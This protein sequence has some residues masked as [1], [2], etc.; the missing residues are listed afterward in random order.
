MNVQS[1]HIFIIALLLGFSQLAWAESLI[2]PVHGLG[3][4]PYMKGQDP[5]HGS[6]I[7]EEQIRDR[8]TVIAPYTKWI[9]SYG[10]THGLEKIGA[11]AHE[12]GLKAAV[13]IWL[14]RDYTE[15]EAQI[16]NAITAAQ[17]GEVDMLIVGNEV[18]LRGDLSEA[19]LIGYINRVKQE[20][21]GI[22]VGYADVYGKFLEY[23]AVVEASD[24]ILA[25]Y[26]PYWEGISINHAME[27]VDFRHQQIIALANGKP[28]I[29]GE[30]G[31]PSDGNTL[32]DAVPSPENAAFYFLS[33]TSW[34]LAN[35]ADYFYFEAFD[36]AWK[37][38]YEGPQG[39]HW[40]VWDEDGILK[41]GMQ[42]VFDGSLRNDVII[43][44]GASYGI[45]RWMNN[46]KWLQLH[47]LSPE[48]MVT[49]DIDGNAQDDVIIDFGTQYGIWVWNSNWGQLHN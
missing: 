2:V 48:S 37:A 9:K 14:S 6:Q 5:N 49:G 31:W 36:E 20:T 34:A 29:V 16:T 24:V 3:F 8:M 19:E 15:N 18:L 40:G 42:T 28:V 33:F 26:Y 35:N 45:W 21:E 23:P 46:N 39:A 25:H 38:Q 7:S 32:G 10:S 30:T 12:L 43:D 11:I 4:S 27:M 44:F 17:A 22:P 13:G 47:N 41:E 1:V